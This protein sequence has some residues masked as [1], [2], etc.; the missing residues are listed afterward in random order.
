MLWLLL[1][2]FVLLALC[3]FAEFAI[4]TVHSSQAPFSIARYLSRLRSLVMPADDRNQRETFFVSV[5]GGGAVRN[6]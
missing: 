5:T 6:G 4:D 1:L 3:W 2:L